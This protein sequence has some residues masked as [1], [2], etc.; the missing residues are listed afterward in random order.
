MPTPLKHLI[1]FALLVAALLIA[2][3]F[4]APG[5]SV[6]STP[7][8]SGLADLPVGSAMAAP[9]CSNKRCDFSNPSKAKCSPASGWKCAAQ[10]QRCVDN[11]CG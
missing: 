2:Q 1:R 8:I 11:L 9:S 10:G 5:D 4:L 7:Y 3:T 6:D